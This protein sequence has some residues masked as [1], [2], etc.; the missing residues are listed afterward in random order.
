[1]NEPIPLCYRTVSLQTQ[2][3]TDDLEC[4]SLIE[5]VLALYPTVDRATIVTCLS[6]LRPNGNG[7]R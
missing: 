4:L 6:A 2:V 5:Q 1:M 3:I 7:T